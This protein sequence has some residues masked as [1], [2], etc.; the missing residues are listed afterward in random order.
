VT[1][2]RSRVLAL[3]PRA[4]A[5]QLPDPTRTQSKPR[6]H[7]RSCALTSHASR[8]WRTRDKAEQGLPLPLSS[9]P[10]AGARCPRPSTAWIAEIPD[11]PF[12][13]WPQP[14]P[15]NPRSRSAKQC[16]PHLQQQLD[17]LDRGH[18]RLGDGGS[19]A[20]GEEVLGEGD[21]LFRHGG[22]ERG[23][24]NGQIPIAWRDGQTPSLAQPCRRDRKDGEA[25]AQPLRTQSHA[26]CPASLSPYA[27]P[28]G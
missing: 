22:V 18:G 16:P 1:G 19:D 8:K 11:R 26:H 10:P 17:P 12:P 24:A 25:S 2:S 15:Q 20:P 3:S 5:L 27:A 7:R 4:C 21:G 6:R 28:I 23:A 13:P 14:E 9:R